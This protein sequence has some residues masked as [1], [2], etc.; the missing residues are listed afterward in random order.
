LDGSACGKRRLVQPLIA[1]F[2]DMSWA[3]ALT[4]DELFENIEIYRDN[5]EFVEWRNSYLEHAVHEKDLQLVNLLLEAGAGPDVVSTWSDSLQHYLVEEYLA[6]R[7]TQGQTV[8]SILEAL[9]SHGANPEH[10]GTNNRRAIDL[11]IDRNV[12]ELRDV[13]VRFGANPEKREFL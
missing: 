12:P 5:P 10:A 13:F 2:D 1:V 7:S 3:R 4:R 8:V 6:L 9:L 11:A